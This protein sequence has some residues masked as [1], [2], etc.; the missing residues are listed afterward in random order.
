MITESY[1]YLA[2]GSNLYY[3]FQS[4]GKQGKIGKVVTFS[5]LQNKFW[6]LGF[7][8]LQGKDIN[9]SVVSNNHDIVKL[10]GTVAQIAYDF[11]DKYPKRGIEITPVD[12][13]RKNLY[14]HVFRRHYEVINAKFHIIGLNNSIAEEYSPEKKYEVFR[15]KRRFA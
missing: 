4:E 11:S 14:N 8:D 10:I 12:E 5:R 7:G 15:L 3:Y 9:D 13:K 6:N 2:L 1:H